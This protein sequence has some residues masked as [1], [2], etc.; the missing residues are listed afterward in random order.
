MSLFVIAIQW[1]IAAIPWIKHQ[2]YNIFMTTVIGSVLALVSAG[3][4]QWKAEK[5]S[6]ARITAKP[7]KSKPVLLTR[8]NGHQY[9]MLIKCQERAWDLET[10]ATARPVYCQGTKWCL[11]TLAAAWIALL[12]TTL[13]IKQDTW[14]LV[15]VG[16]MGMV[17][18]TVVAAYPCTPEELDI[19]LTPD[20]TCSTIIGY[21]RTHESKKEYLKQ[22]FDES[23]DLEGSKTPKDVR[24]VMGAIMELEKRFPKAGKALLPIFFPGG[25]EALLGAEREF[26]ERVNTK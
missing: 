16:I 24:D 12:F 17:Q 2:N 8:G 9:A 5:W 10:M 1:V 21:Q 4:P 3:L 13:G 11:W 6:A 22:A 14:Y 15:G 25:K 23:R 7:P 26:W 20:E 19:V 18:N